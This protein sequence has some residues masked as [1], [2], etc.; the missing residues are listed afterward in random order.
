MNRLYACRLAVV[1]LGAA[2]LFSCVK[3]PADG[4]KAPAVDPGKVSGL[5]VPAGFDWRMSENVAL[6]I[7][8]AHAT[9]VS[10]YTAAD[11]SGSSRLASLT[12]D[13]LA[14]DDYL[15]GVPAGTSKLYVKYEKES[16]AAAVVPVAV[17]GAKATCTVPADSK[18]VV[19]TKEGNSVRKGD[20]IFMPADGWGTL[21][22]EDLWPSYGDFDFNDLVVNY[23]NQ[24]YI[25]NKNMIAEMVGGIRVKAVGGSLPYE[26]YLQLDGVRGVH[27]RSV[28]VLETSNADGATVELLNPKDSKNPAVLAFRNIKKNPFKPEGSIY[29]N[30]EAGYEVG[31][32]NLVSLS[33]HIEFNGVQKNEDLTSDK[34]NYFLAQP[35]GAGWKEI[36]A[37]GF[38]PSMEMGDA[39]YQAIK[40]VSPVI[41]EA[42]YYYSNEHLVWGLNVPAAIPHAYEHVDFLKAYP[43]FGKWAESGGT[44]YQDWYAN[45]AGNRVKENLV[46]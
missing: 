22:F 19:G 9:E 4:G 21:M 37:G 24:L 10:V 41:D 17:S 29:L 43:N 44:L 34:F 28:E 31:E 2:T 42:D 32:E 12:V 20:V 26:F 6:K 33:Y 46:E 5:S 30:T 35:D 27:V 11:C 45:K 8:A 23:K 18:A 39:A 1:A 16:G 25:Q 7:D 36:H 40:K 13:E 3:E 38:A 14:G 15:L